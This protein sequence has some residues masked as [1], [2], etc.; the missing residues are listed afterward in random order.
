MQDTDHSAPPFEVSGAVD[1]YHAGSLLASLEE[2]IRSHA[3]IT[4]DLSRA[5]SFDMAGVQLLRAAKKTAE[6]AGKPFALAGVPESLRAIEKALG[7]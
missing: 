7:L 2:H 5:D 1:V 6:E 3:V 4:I